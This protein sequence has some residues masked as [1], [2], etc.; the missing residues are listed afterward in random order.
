[1]YA[2]WLT[3]RLVASVQP[4]GVV[5]VLSEL[6][7]RT[8]YVVALAVPP[9]VYVTTVPVA[10]NEKLCGVP[11]TNGAVTGRDQ[12]TLTIRFVPLSHV[13]GVD[14]VPGCTGRPVPAS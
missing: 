4:D 5:T 12:P 2:P 6:M 14:V 10:V 3:T 9:P 11:V 8:S 1:M 7:L 13:I